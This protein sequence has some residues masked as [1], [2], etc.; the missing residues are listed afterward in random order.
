MGNRFI[1]LIISGVV[2]LTAAVHSVVVCVLRRCWRR[3][4]TC[5]ERFQRGKTALSRT[6]RCL[7]VRV[8]P[9]LILGGLAFLLFVFQEISANAF[10]CVIGS[11]ILVVVVWII[12]D[13]R[14]NYKEID[15]AFDLHDHIENLDRINAGEMI[16]GLNRIKFVEPYIP[17]EPIDTIRMRAMIN[18]IARSALI[19]SIYRDHH[20][21]EIMSYENPMQYIRTKRDLV[22]EAFNLG[23]HEDYLQLVINRLPVA[24]SLEESIES[25]ISNLFVDV[26]APSLIRCCETKI[27]YYEL[28]LKD[29]TM[30]RSIREKAKLFKAKN[31]EYIV[32][33]REICNRSSVISSAI[34]SRER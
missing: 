25:Y 23:H 27:A 16:E 15:I 14:I 20:C 12:C 17:G 21:R 19:P 24:V 22:V 13:G 29:R 32:N 6:W 2:R 34:K 30:S 1:K 4:A 18:E 9:V 5:N 8:S 26:F 3:S 7:G 11:S 31:E 10:F 33:V 28:V